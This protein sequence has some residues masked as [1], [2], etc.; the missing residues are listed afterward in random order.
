MNKDR[1]ISQLSLVPFGNKGWMHSDSTV[2]IFGCDRSDKF[3]IKFLD[4][5]GVVMCMRCGESTSLHVYLL[6]IN[7]RDLVGEYSAPV[8]DTLRSVRKD[9]IQEDD[10]NIG[11]ELP[12]GFKRIYY[13]EYLDSRGF[14]YSQ[15]NHFKVGVSTDISLR[16]HLIFPIYQDGV[17]SSWLG[18]TRYSKEWHKENIK[19]YK[20]QRGRLIPRYKNSAGTEFSEILGG[21][22]D[23]VQGKTDTVILVEGIF[24]KANVDRLGNLYDDD[25]HAVK[26]CF[27]F[28]KNLSEKQVEKILKKGV[29]NLILMYD[30][31]AIDEI[32]KFAL[33]YINKFDKISCARLSENDPGD[34]DEQEFNKI[35]HNLKTPVDFYFNNIKRI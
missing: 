9:E 21:L 31:D 25:T 19:S 16:E 12:R 22:D 28:G 23:I 18:R 3:G 7:R 14:T 11:C 32:Q 30:P 29:K 35:L 20:E 34:M 6:K 15:Y 2:C 24:D 33:Q 8:Q 13:D 26:C 1:I 4:R 5:G 10:I 17:L 27:T